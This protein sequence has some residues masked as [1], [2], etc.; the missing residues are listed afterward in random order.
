MLCARL[1]LLPRAS[2]IFERIARAIEEMA[3]EFEREVEE[4][5]R[6]AAS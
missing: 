1:L 4:E 3:E 6:R 2:T 5:A